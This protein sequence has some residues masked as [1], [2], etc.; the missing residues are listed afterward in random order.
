MVPYPI[1][2]TNLE[3]F[4]ALASIVKAEAAAR[5]IPIAWGGDWTNLKDM[6]HYELDP[7]R[8]FAA[9]ARPFDG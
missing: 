9:N 8:S 5:D 4:R 7:W 2:W 1:D 3:R 6:P